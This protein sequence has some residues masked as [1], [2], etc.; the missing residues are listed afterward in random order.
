[1]TLSNKSSRNSNSRIRII[2]VFVILATFLVVASYYGTKTMS[3][4]RAYVTGEGLWSKA[5]KRATRHILEYMQYEELN[6]YK[7]F[8]ETLI[9]HNQFST[10]RK[11]M[12][13]DPPD[14]KT[15]RQG[16]RAS[17]LHPTDIEL[18]V[19]LGSNFHDF[20]Y[21]KESFEIWKNAD[22]KIAEL[23]SVAQN[24]HQQA[25]QEKM[26]PRQRKEYVQ[27][28]ARIDEELT[29][30]E[31]AFTAT[32]TSVAH[33]LR[34]IIFWFIAGFGLLLTVVGYLITAADFK[35]IND[36]NTKLERLSLVA[37]KTTDA[38]IITDSQERIIW[39]NAMFEKLT[40]Y[41]QQEVKGRVPGEILQGEETDTETVQ[42]LAMA[43]GEE[44]SIRKRILNYTKE[45][46]KL[47]LDIT[48]DPIFN[49]EGECTN[50]I[51]I[52][53][54][55]TEQIQKE[56]KVRE[57]L[58]RYDVVAQA[59]SDTIYDLDLEKNEISYNEVVHDMFGYD[60]TEIANL[61][62][63]WEK[64]IHPNDRQDVVSKVDKVIE[65]GKDRFQIEYRFKCKNGSYKHIFDRASVVRDE[66]DNPVRIIG[67]MQDITESK[68]A[69]QKEERHRLLLQSIT[70]NVETPIWI[71]NKKGNIILANK[72][73]KKLFNLENKEVVGHSMFDLLDSEVAKK[74]H[75]NDLNIISN[76]VT[77][78]FYES[79][80]IDGVERYFVT[81][82]FS[83]DDVPGLENAIGGVAIDITARRQAE[84]KL[85]AAEQ[86]LRE[87]V[88]HS[89]NM[90]YRHTTD[91]VLTYVSPQSR[92][93]LGCRP[94]EA[95]TKWTEFVTDNPQ[96]KE[97]LKKTEEAIR[98]GETQEPF[99]LELQKKTGDIIWVEVNEAP[100]VKDGET[101]AMV[102][103]LTN[104]TER[105]KAE[106]EIKDALKEKETL[107]AEVHHRVKNN[108]AVVSGMMQLQAYQEEDP[109]LE[110]K[111]LDNVAR[112]G[113]MASI[114]EHIYQ[115]EMFSSIA[116][117]QNIRTIADKL[118][119]T[120]QVETDIKITTDLEEVELALNQAIPSSLIISE[121][122]T[123]A[124]KHAFKDR[125]KGNLQLKVEKKDRLV[126]VTVK[127]DGVGLPNYFNATNES[128]SLGM[129]LIQKLTKQLDGTYEYQPVEE[130]TVFRLSFKK[131]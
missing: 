83:L 112:I 72:A 57:S 70:E 19:W 101:V 103:S 20:T 29:G 52:E 81:S 62:K 111:L 100:I 64:K 77:Q 114:H 55:I 126:D 80:K 44:E 119:D 129:H 41:S 78:T 40:G 108:M 125:A 69:K 121:V 95:K 73:W 56:A 97:G 124:L 5:Q 18:M 74:F 39:V 94:E 98:T 46:E 90:F 106:D 51:A 13:S 122:I 28:I 1:M 93:F 34:V 30:Y 104:I 63:W 92:E 67:A 130:G 37:S 9:L 117:S 96:N 35:K 6:D 118:V 38:V 17:Q 71:R 89:T 87:I 58:E 33:G 50:F 4:V 15:A 113:T 48:I 27:K 49:D 12:I 54:D 128:D 2:A 14:P 115:S 79:V 116:F 21:V 16:F 60:K 8:K 31:D 82:M 7:Q 10:S 3:A 53:R 107:L 109:Q 102:G 25:L 131:D 45:G 75:E 47:W 105:K 22:R 36:L 26:S 23:E 43:I 42:E 99:E 85:N 84:N 32:L 66:R 91:H 68:K 127:D 120:M 123:N 65:N 59:T 61:Q 88:E 11:A 76:R 24:F 86:K 110:S